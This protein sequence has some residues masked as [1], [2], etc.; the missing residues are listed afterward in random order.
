VVPAA[1]LSGRRHAP[2][3]E[4]RRVSEPR[5]TLEVDVLFVGAGPANLAGAYHLANLVRAHD[6]AIAAGTKPGEPIGEIQIAVIEKAL[7]VG[8]HT[9]SGAVLDPR[10]LAELMPDY[11]AQ[12]AP[13]ASP[14]TGEDIYFL[15][16]GGKLRFPITPPPLANHGNYVLSLNDF[17]R[18]LGG[19]VEEQGT[20][21]LPSTPATQPL[22]ED[23]RLVG[24]RTGD[25]GIDRHGVRKANFEPGSDL[26]ARA[27]VFGEGA[28]GS[29]HKHLARRMGLESPDHPQ[30]YGIG[31]KELW[32]IPA[33]RFPRGH[34]AHTMGFPLPAETY[35][36]GFVYG[37][38]ETLL[39]LGLVVGLDYHDPYTDGHRET[40]RW[41]AH[42]YLRA[43]LE[44]GKLVSYGARAIPLGGYYA[45]PQLA[46][47]GA[48]FAGD[49]AGFLNAQRLKGI[50]LGMKSGMLAAETI[51]EGLV[52]K[53]LSAERLRGYDAGFRASWAYGEMY[54]GRNFHQGFDH[55]LYAGMIF[56]AVQM[57]TG[58]WAPYQGKPTVPG[59]KRM[60][61]LRERYG[62]TPPPP[63]A[64]KYDGVTGFDKLTE[65]YPSGTQHEED[66]PVHLLVADTE[67]CRTRCVE[68]YGNPCFH[69]CPANV[70]EMVPDA[71][72]GGVRLQIN[73]ANCVHCKTCDIADP[74]GIID[75]VPPEGG[76]GP[77]YVKL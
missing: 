36:G 49:S 20:Y 1:A 57:A 12:G 18:W 60:R 14:V 7:E 23:G 70:Y 64:K 10:A 19:K 4:D 8:A 6:A 32:E 66:Q 67:I 16:D 73:A 42:P 58:G 74:Y 5:E 63:P 39:A 62:D 75:W 27:T 68:E 22:F 29:M 76:G 54:R 17:V 37:M 25:K 34:V 55:G 31:V 40:Q 33:G 30:I 61:P 35:G 9:V 69:F 2:A 38:D 15:T 45:M 53:D 59:H 77:R 13:L 56:T 65:L 26:R 21:V 41:K 52:A 72:R 51:F 43:I 24:V 47:D 3:D 11:A 46:I 50:H 44:G 71:E 28:R 48:L